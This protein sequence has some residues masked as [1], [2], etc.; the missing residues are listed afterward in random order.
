MCIVR[1]SFEGVGENVKGKRSGYMWWG[2]GRE[3]EHIE[4]AM[5]AFPPMARTS[6]QQIAT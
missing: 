1:G 2:Y 3:A 4:P 5:A 6:C